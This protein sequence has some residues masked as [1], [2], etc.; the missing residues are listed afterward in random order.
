MQRIR[1]G[2]MG[3]GAVGRQI[4]QLALAR[5]DVEIPVV[6]D[7]GRPDILHHLLCR[8]EVAVRRGC[9]SARWRR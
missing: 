7:I 2:I 3:F 6:S 4:Y 5:S 8:D 1:L 9:G